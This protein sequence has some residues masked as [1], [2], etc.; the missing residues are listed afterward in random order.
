M[1]LIN[2]VSN[3]EMQENLFRIFN[4][5]KPF[6][7]QMNLLC[8]KDEDYAIETNVRTKEVTETPYRLLGA[9]GGTRRAEEAI[10]TLSRLIAPILLAPC[11][12]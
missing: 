6:G 8:F 12:F 3:S 10:L 2:L 7:R 9:P 4:F 11:M 1:N 5:Q